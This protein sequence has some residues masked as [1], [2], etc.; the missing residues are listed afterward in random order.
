M[1]RAITVIEPLVASLDET[2]RS[3]RLDVLACAMM[4]FALAGLSSYA[5]HK[6]VR[7]VVARHQGLDVPVFG[8]VPFVARRLGGQW[9]VNLGAHEG[10]VPLMGSYS[11]M[12]IAPSSLPSDAFVRAVRRTVLVGPTLNVAVIAVAGSA[13]WWI[14]ETSA[15]SSEMILS[16]VTFGFL[17]ANVALLAMLIPGRIGVLRSDG[18]MIRLLSDPDEAATIRSMYR[19]SALA[20]DS[21]RPRDWS[22][23]DNQTLYRTVL[24]QARTPLQ[25]EHRTEA[26]LLLTMAYLDQGRPD[27]ASR[28]SEHMLGS[29]EPLGSVGCPLMQALVVFAAYHAVKL[30]AN[31]SHAQ[32]LLNRI[33]RLANIRAGTMFKMSEAALAL[34]SGH[35]DKARRRA[36]QA[37]RTGSRAARLFPIAAVELDIVDAMLAELGVSSSRYGGAT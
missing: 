32:A 14:G 20:V 6:A 18:A 19:T 17:A 5:A 1:S 21:R 16:L 13:S 31:P 3:L 12:S 10:T 29:I 26:A 37:R 23:D 25:R 24:A 28:L 9:R 4:A 36:N 15:M 8:V 11:F 2:L 27:D 22:T 30:D 33:P 7:I 35:R 34:A